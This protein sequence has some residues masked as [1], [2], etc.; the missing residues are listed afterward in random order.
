LADHAEEINHDCR[1][2]VLNMVQG[3]WSVE[4]EQT[5]AIGK[6]DSLTEAR[7]TRREGDGRKTREG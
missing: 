6:R 4:A 1:S 7:R 3:A 2:C 5:I